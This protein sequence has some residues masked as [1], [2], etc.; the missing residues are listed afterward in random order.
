MLEISV[1][2][3]LLITAFVLFPQIEPP[4]PPPFDPPGA[5]INLATG[6]GKANFFPIHINTITLFCCHWLTS[7]TE[8]N[9]SIFKNI[10]YSI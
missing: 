7:S 8:G 4:L 5:A 2:S 10:T 9:F 3:S 1:L 6:N